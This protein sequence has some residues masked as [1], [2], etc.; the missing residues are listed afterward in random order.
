MHTAVLLFPVALKQELW[1]VAAGTN[2]AHK[3]ATLSE[4]P[5]VLSVDIPNLKRGLEVRRSPNDGA[6]GTKR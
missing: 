3:S 2:Q 4:G 1:S 5:S 6:I